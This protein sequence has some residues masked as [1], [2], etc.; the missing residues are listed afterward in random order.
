VTVGE[1]W[2]G[3]CQGQQPANIIQDMFEGGGVPEGAFGSSMPAPIER[4]EDEAGTDEGLRHVVIA[5]GMFAVAVGQAD[6]ASR[7]RRRIPAEPGQAQAVLGEDMSILRRGEA[8]RWR[9][10]RHNRNTGR[11]GRA[12]AAGMLGS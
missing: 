4:Q 7:R 1:A 8:R 3:R 9:D 5:P 12:T 6:R 2:P 10:G 11:R